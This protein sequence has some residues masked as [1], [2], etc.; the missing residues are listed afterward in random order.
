MTKEEALSIVAKMADKAS[1]LLAAATLPGLPAQLHLDGL[2]H[3]LEDI[4][5]ELKRA[6]IV[7]SGENPWP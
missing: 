1:N 5:A 6:Y 2:R 7:L 3:G 4:E